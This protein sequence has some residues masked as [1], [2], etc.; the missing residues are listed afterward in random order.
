VSTRCVKPREERVGHLRSASLLFLAGIA[1]TAS[2]MGQVP[3]TENR[4]GAFQFLVGEWIGE[5]SGDPGQATGGF[6]IQPDLQNSV[7]VRRNSAKYP[8]TKDR[9]AF[10][11][12][13]L[14]VMYYEDGR[15]GAV[16]FD[17][18][19]HVIRYSVEFSKDS[20]SVVFLSDPVPSA[21]R[22]RFTYVKTGNGTLNI[23]FDI[24]QPDKP[25]SFSRYIEA[26]ARRKG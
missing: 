7:L 22:F 19:G 11:H 12:D 3:R 23:T 6:T 14:M 26:T 5:G 18:E 8:A 15:P 24:A 10:I 17:S 16:Y 20:S 1:L 13:D 21:P 4:W 2:S 9:P 25:E